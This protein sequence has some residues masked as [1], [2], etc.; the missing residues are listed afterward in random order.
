MSELVLPVE[1]T[2]DVKKTLYQPTTQI[3]VSEQ[4]SGLRQRRI[5]TPAILTDA[6]SK[7][8]DART[9]AR[10]DQSSISSLEGQCLSLQ[11]QLCDATED[12]KQLS[13]ELKSKD[14]ELSDLF[15]Q[16]SMMERSQKSQVDGLQSQ[17][18]DLKLA[19]LELRE[20]I[21]KCKEEKQSLIEELEAHVIK[22]ESLMQEIKELNERVDYML[23][24]QEGW[25]VYVRLICGKMNNA[26]STFF[27][28]CICAIVCMGVFIVVLLVVL[29]FLS[30][31]AHPLSCPNE[32]YM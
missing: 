9:Q 32:N 22:E 1:S 19:D 5:D 20:K 25:F 31:S 14:R 23:R 2:E 4:E 17:V 7:L 30:V 21:I 12:M 27:V 11:K 29:F 3:C 18:E 6:I 24:E 16:K 8:Y 13:E 26:M 28:I 10:S 15:Y